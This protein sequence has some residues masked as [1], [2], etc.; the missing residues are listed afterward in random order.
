MQIAQIPKTGHI[1]K[2][3]FLTWISCRPSVNAQHK[4]PAAHNSSALRGTY[5]KALLTAVALKPSYHYRTLF[6]DKAEGGPYVL[7]IQLSSALKGI[8]YIK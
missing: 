4:T 5:N 7:L 1:K 3:D 8:T 2:Y 6:Q